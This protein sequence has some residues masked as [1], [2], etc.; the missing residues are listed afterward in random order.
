MAKFCN[1]LMC[2][3]WK[4][5]SSPCPRNKSRRCN[6]SIKRRVPRHSSAVAANMSKEPGPLGFTT[7]WGDGV[8]TL[9]V[10]YTQIAALSSELEG[11]VRKRHVDSTFALRYFSRIIRDDKW[12]AGGGNISA[13]AERNETQIVLSLQS[14]GEARERTE[15]RCSS[16]SSLLF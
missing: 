9:T 10:D 2:R 8:K 15:C 11:N 1:P 6:A 4:Q 5:T 7:E 16:N 13:G 14:P 12:D 3:V